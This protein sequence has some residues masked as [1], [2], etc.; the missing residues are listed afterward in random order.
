MN[1]GTEKTRRVAITGADGFIGTALCSALEANEVYS[2]KRLLQAEGFELQDAS[3]DDWRKGFEGSDICIHL[4]SILP[5][6]GDNFDASAEERFLNIYAYA[7][8]SLL[9]AL[10]AEGG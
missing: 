9:R 10:H 7:S 8:R 4:A 1:A 2:V 6:S 3:A 5:W